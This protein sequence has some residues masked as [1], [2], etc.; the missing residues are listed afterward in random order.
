MLHTIYTYFL[1]QTHIHVALQ[2]TTCIIVLSIL[3]IKNVF[4]NFIAWEMKTPIFLEAL[5]TCS[6]S[7][8]CTTYFP[9]LKWDW[10]NK[11]WSHL[12]KNTKHQTSIISGK[13]QT[14][15]ILWGHI[16]PQLWYSKSTNETF[17]FL[18]W[19]Y[20]KYV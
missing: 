13:N 10:K 16:F 5:H 18:D 11:C 12:V 14:G 19:W 6:Y 20:Q 15:K 3:L 1:F 2:Y 9:R 8:K 7:D 4:Y 17:L